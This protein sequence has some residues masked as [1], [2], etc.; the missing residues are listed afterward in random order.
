MLGSVGVVASVTDNRDAQR[1]QG[2]TRY[3]IVSSQS[4]F[5]RP[6]PATEQGRSQLQDM[7]DALA[8]IFI[9]R[10][11]LFRNTTAD[12][13]AQNFG[14]GKILI[15][16]Q[17][18]GAGMA[19]EVTNFEPLV[20]RLAADRSPRAF[21]SATTTKEL[22][23]AEATQAVAPPNPTQTPTPVAA[24]ATPSSPQATP[25]EQP[26]PAVNER[27]RMR[28]ILSAPEAQGREQMARTLALETDLDAAAAIKV[29][30]SSPKQ[31]PANPLAAE[32]AFVANPK[33]GAGGGDGDDSPQSEAARILA[34]VPQA[35]R[36]KAAN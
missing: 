30:A 22:P 26:R 23:M 35:R 25:T 9:S 32:M 5:K 1:R 36:V 24:P 15:A 34:F 6:D 31:G 7:V 20:A 28:A 17:A 21:I 13:V 3:E 8:D 10:L 2:V 18:I 33:V 14:Q 27:E 16:K 4:P 12:N 29:L 19:D 11:A